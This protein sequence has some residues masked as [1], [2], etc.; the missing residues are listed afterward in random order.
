MPS[1]T[2]TTDVVI[3]T[4]GLSKDYHRVRAVDGLDLTVQRGAIYALVGRCGSG[5]T[6][7]AR[8]L[9]GLILPTVGEAYVLGRP[10]RRT[11]VEI[12]ERVGYL[13][14]KSAFY[15]GLTARE[16]LEVQRRLFG[17]RARRRIDEVL[18]V[19]GMLDCGDRKVR[20]LSEDERQRLGI[21]RALLHEPELLV[22]DEPA[23]RLDAVSVRNLRELLEHLVFERQVTV[24]LCDQDIGFAEQVATRIGVLHNGRL[25]QDMDSSEVGEH[26]RDYLEVTVS[27]SRRAAWLIEEL[28]DL[29][30]YAVL[31]DGVLRIYES[32]DRS[33]EINRCLQENGIDVSRLT[34]ERATLEEYFVDVTGADEE[35]EQ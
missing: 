2:S 11:E 21:A 4:R 29:D 26:R 25:A 9:L 14:D 35:G 12:R 1:V 8:M 22:L 19:M 17:I 23:Q 13:P 6:T 32:L 20:H 7:V 33:A 28:L 24:F 27:D 16:T 15:S 10:V 31:R 5:K 18:D 3:R 30:D 34:T